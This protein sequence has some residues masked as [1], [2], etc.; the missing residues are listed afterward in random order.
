MIT[1]C[2]IPVLAKYKEHTLNGNLETLI[3]KLE[4][5]KKST[6]IRLA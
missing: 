1:V 2:L 3:P 4:A 6:A 5:R